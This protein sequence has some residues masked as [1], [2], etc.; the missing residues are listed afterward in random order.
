MKRHRQDNT[1]EQKE[2]IPAISNNII[3]MSKKKKKSK[4]LMRSSVLTAIR[5]F[6]MQV[7]IPNIEETSTDS[8]NF[9]A[10]N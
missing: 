6:L 1:K 5:K 4:A 8:D 3:N 2:Q 7:S 9:Y 10:N